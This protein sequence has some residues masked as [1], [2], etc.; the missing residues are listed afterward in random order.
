MATGSHPDIDVLLARLREIYPNA[1]YELD[2]S[3][4]IQMLVATILAAQ[5]TDERVN[6]VTATLFADYPDAA[7]FAAVDRA[8][9]EEAVRPTG[10]Y[11]QKAKS[12]QECCQAIL[13]RFGGEVPQTIAE[14]ITLP[15]VARKTA[16]VVLGNAFNLAEGFVVDTHIERLAKRFALADPADNV[17]A[18]E[19]KLMALL[20]PD[21]WC[22]ASHELIFHGRRVCKA[23]LPA[24]A[25]NPI[26]RQFGDRC[27]LRITAPP[28]KKKPAPR[29]RASKS[30]R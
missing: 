16:N 19:R 5:C 30:A 14:L 2:W 21:R 10:F 9:L 17:A 26:C 29:A 15:G 27:E 4:P 8:T 12:I 11:K 7:A 3:T 22:S 18:V 28:P 6:A 13:D 25:D 23:R 1:R 24:C 20:P